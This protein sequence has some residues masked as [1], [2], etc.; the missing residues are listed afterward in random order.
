[1]IRSVGILAFGTMLCMGNA[2]A[3]ALL[4]ATSL[5][6][7]RYIPLAELPQNPNVGV[8]RAVDPL[9]VYSDVTTFTGQAFAQG[10]A[11]GGITRLVMDDLTFTTNAGVGNVTTIRFAVANLNAVSH[12]VRARIRFWNADGSPLGAGLPNG[13]GTYY[14]PGGTAVGYSFNPFTFGSG[15]T[16]LSGNLG[17]G[18]AI[19][20]GT[21]TTLWAGITF[22]NV[23]TTTGATDADL[24]NFGQGFFE[25][26]D[27][28]SST[29]T[30]F[31]TTAAGSFFT[32]AN[33]A[34]SA[35][36][37]G[38]SPVANAGWEFVV[39]DLGTPPSADLSIT[40]T[41]GVTSVSPGG[42]TT[43]TIVASNAGP[44]A[45]NGATV[46]DTFPA[47]LTCT[48]TCVGAGGGTC[49]AS[50][51]GNINDLV[52]LPNA[53]STTYTASCSISGSAT[54]SLVNTATVTAPAGVTDPTPG[55][56]S[57]TDT[58]TINPPG[59]LTIAPTSL[60]FGDVAVGQNS[61]TQSV[62]LGNNGGSPLQVTALT[63]AASPFALVG[64][65][66]SG[67]PITIAASS[68]CTL[69]YRFNPASTGP[70]TQ[71]LA[72]TAN[73]TG[74]GSI[75]LDGNGVVGAIGVLSATLDFGT[76]VTG[77]NGQLAMTIVNTGTGPLQVTDISAVSAPFQQVAGGSC[78]ATSFP[79]AASG[80]CTVLYEFSPTSAGSFTQPVV[81]TADVG[82]VTV[83]LAGVGAN[84]ATAARE[85]PTLGQWTIALLGLLL[86]YAGMTRLQSRRH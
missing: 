65:T 1:M 7:E 70:A 69:D 73:T 63:A 26:V 77:A 15:V 84:G 62:T 57:A 42:S 13:P 61:A 58:D 71:I 14:S 30:I 56:N 41:D 6:V 72:V 21:T 27:L 23:G 45:A 19:P 49:T 18:F 38:G 40:K 44:D 64:G 11:S 43:Y 50:G 22:D 67:V 75:A 79:I 35:V 5:H 12:S 17:A 55:N 46:A 78:P 80:S 3:E 68:S 47:S 31:E 4:P 51:S 60:S 53:A 52:N 74:S 76:V 24:S 32:T 59:N 34:G 29:D 25:P 85:L 8:I 81:I 66:C 39:S 36:N 54:G 2:A 37:F 86:A 20:A 48:W 10:A 9:A 28:G 33:P 82:S 83:T 16:I